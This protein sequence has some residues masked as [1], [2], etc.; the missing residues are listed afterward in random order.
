MFRI[1]VYSISF[2][3]VCLAIQS[4][5]YI[6]TVHRTSILG[7]TGIYLALLVFQKS[8]A[9]VDRSTMISGLTGVV[10]FLSILAFGDDSRGICLMAIGVLFASCGILARHE[11]QICFR[12]WILLIFLALIYNEVF[13][14]Q[15]G[16]CHSWRA[17][18]SQEV[19]YL[20]SQGQISFNPSA[21]GIDTT[22][23]AILTLAAG[24]ISNLK[25]FW[26]LGGITAALLMQCVVLGAASFLPSSAWSLAVG[27]S[28]VDIDSPSVGQPFRI[29]SAY[30][31]CSLLAL[32]CALICGIAF[33]IGQRTEK[34]VTSIKFFA[35]SI[36]LLLVFSTVLSLERPQ[37][38]RSLAGLK[39]GLLCDWNLDA[40]T[41]D[42]T[43][44][45]LVGTGMYGLM[46]KDLHTRGAE[47]ALLNSGSPNNGLPLQ[48]NQGIPKAPTRLP[49]GVV[50][51]HRGSGLAD[52]TNLDAVVVVVPNRSFTREETKEFDRFLESGG[53]ALVVGDHTNMLNCMDSC[54]QLTHKHGLSLQFDSA[55]S[56]LD[57]WYG[58][59]DFNQSVDF[60]PGCWLDFG[61]ATGASVKVDSQASV[62][63]SGR[64]AFGDFGNILNDSMK[65]GYLGDYSYQHGEL[66]GDVPLIASRDVGEGTLICFGDSSMFQNIAY[67]RSGR[68]VRHMFSYSSTASTNSFNLWTLSILSFGLVG[69]LFPLCNSPYLFTSL[70]LLIPPLFLGVGTTPVSETNPDIHSQ[71]IVILDSHTP[72]LN[73]DSFRATSCHGL[74][75]TIARSGR[76]PKFG[77]SIDESVTEQPAAICILGIRNQL[78]HSDASALRTYLN[79][80]GTVII[81]ADPACQ[82][83]VSVLL[84]EY[85]IRVSDKPL[86]GEHY[87]KDHNLLAFV[88]SWALEMSKDSMAHTVHRR[89][90]LP[91]IA[92]VENLSLIHI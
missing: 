56:H 50:A 11:N 41:D 52:L 42:P 44:F 88:D 43:T 71:E 31:I 9:E 38:N 29:F 55:F 73:R 7:L 24:L 15:S 20:I 78:S 27:L 26:V 51:E 34:H 6:L 80:G 64:W 85:G 87:Q 86:G 47:I 46:V 81:T 37:P 90:G 10:L 70:S 92:E 83:N 25:P 54:N 12:S 23:L 22:I 72:S 66:L 2:L 76:F 82:K 63:L 49:A 89:L 45:G 62:L 30:E 69:C 60:K 33:L 39:I 8:W 84:D 14:Q 67:A 19:S 18:L 74:P 16:W 21:S 35:S 91:V 79:H 4:T 75:L 58:N 61:V 28:E 48:G 40:P 53:T 32:G 59:L 1:A 3:L 65:G 57:W 36:L 77:Y 68:F 5:G 17:G 13:I